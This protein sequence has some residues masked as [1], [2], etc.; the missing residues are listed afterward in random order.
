MALTYVA[1][2]RLAEW[3]S[4]SEE[5][6]D[7]RA[8]A[9]SDFF[10]YYGDE[11]T[12]YPGNTGE[13]NRRERR[14]L[15]YFAFS[16]ELPDG[17][18]PSELAAIAFLRGRE[19]D[20]ALKT[21]RTVRYVT[22]VASRINPGRGFYLQMEDEGFGIESSALSRTIEKGQLVSAHLIRTSRD[23]YLL[24]PGWV[25]WPIMAGPGI[26]G[27]LKSVFQP[28]PIEVERFLQGRVHRPDRSDQIERPE[29]DTLQAAVARMSEAAR[30]AGRTGLIM[31][32]EE[33]QK[34]VLPYLRRRDMSRFADELH[35]RAAKFESVAD[36][37]KWLALATNI[38]N[39]T[40]Q[41]DRGG[42]SPNQLLREARRHAPR[43][44]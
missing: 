8:K 27:Q 11:P 14:F 41:P 38:W 44:L 17:R 13:L 18:R 35:R 3:C 22:G 7:V 20:T 15:G 30:E 6:A 42:K 33:W 34:V 21:I 24:A 36:A 2:E 29:D 10:G 31:S 5:I 37:N 39:N 32:P 26:R 12:D 40:P 16:F 4:K 1:V 43:Q 23:R 25:A 19:L 9:R 28:D